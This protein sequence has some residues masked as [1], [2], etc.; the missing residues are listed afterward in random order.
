M[1]VCWLE[2]LLREFD[3]ASVGGDGGRGLRADSVCGRVL[4]TGMGPRAQM[5][6]NT[7]HNRRDSTRST[8]ATPA[9]PLHRY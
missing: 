4:Y 9:P 5:R 7:Q 8:R 1:T 6:H 3:A 2:S